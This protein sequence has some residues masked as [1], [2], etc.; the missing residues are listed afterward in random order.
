MLVALDLTAR[1]AARVL[2]QAVQTH[3]KLEIDPRPET[4][5]ASLWGSL[6]SQQQDLL[7][8]NLLGAGHE[9]PRTA[10]IGAMCDVRT[11]LSGQ[12]YLFSSFIVD[13]TDDTAPPRLMLAVP[14]A[15]Q[16]ANRRRFARKS[17]SEPVP[18]RL[19]VP[20][21]PEPFIAHLANIAGTGLGCRVLRR[22]LDDLLFIGDRVEIE[23]VLP[24]AGHIYQLPGTVCS[25]T[26]CRD[27]DYML[28]GFEFAVSENAAARASL[29]LLRSVLHS[30]T[31]R[32][33][34]MEGDL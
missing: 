8:V 23:F 29:E 28:V 5:D 9:T 7:Q 17:P 16:V 31:T 1:Q 26:P 30:E 20:S 32:L 27:R 24:W 10:L 18:V 21:T 11:I 3:A 22:E 19:V 4:S 6:E 25:K 13:A 34:E 15:I 12:L 2:A 14:E 33:I